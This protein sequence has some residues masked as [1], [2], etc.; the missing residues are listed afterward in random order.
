MKKIIIFSA[1]LFWCFN[2]TVSQTYTATLAIDDIEVKELKPGDDVIVPV[3]LAEKSGGLVAGFQLFI[4]YD[5]SVFSWKGT[6]QDPL[7]GINAVHQNCKYSAGDWIFNDNGNQF[8]AIWID[9]ALTGV[10]INKGEVIGEFV[11]TYQGGLQPGDKSPLIW[12]NSFE[13]NEGVVVK[14]PTEVTSELIDI[15][16]LTFIN[17]S[18]SIVK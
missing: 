2:I 17:G 9:P 14:G 8:V 1:F 13:L 11:F 4:G 3:K 18:I 15:F 12:G 7:P 5:H 6:T 16:V 10:Q